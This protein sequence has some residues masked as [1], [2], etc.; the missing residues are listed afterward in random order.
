MQRKHF[1][2]ICALVLV[3]VSLSS[4]VLPYRQTDKGLQVIHLKLT[5]PGEK[6]IRACVVAGGMVRITDHKAK[7]A[8]AYLP[9]V[10]DEKNGGVSI[11]VFRVNNPDTEK[12][13]EEVETFD[14]SFKSGKS[15]TNSP[16][17]KI[18]VETIG[19]SAPK[20]GARKTSEGVTALGGDEE[21]PGECCVTCGTLTICSN[22]TVSHTCG[23][24]CTSK[25]NAPACACGPGGIS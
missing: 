12:N 24:C 23:S 2:A 5:A 9:T 3:L 19:R 13:L 25:P 6:P 16:T 21:G 17:Y 18:E 4:T 15:T 22:C 10:L 20:S 14:V 1:N 8:F 7:T 11:K